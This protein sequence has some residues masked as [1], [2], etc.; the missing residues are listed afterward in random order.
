M[1]K[2]FHICLNFINRKYFRQFLRKF[3]HEIIYYLILQRLTIILQTDLYYFF[4]EE[5][6][7]YVIIQI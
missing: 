4:L 3:K 1:Y 2:I 7:I 6:Y 5:F